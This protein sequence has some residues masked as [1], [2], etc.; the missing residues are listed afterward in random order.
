M[1]KKIERTIRN[2]RNKAKYYKNFNRKYTDYFNF[3]FDTTAHLPAD[4]VEVMKKGCKLLDEMGIKYSLADGTLLGVVRDNKLIPHDTDIDIAVLHPADAKQ[5]EKIFT[6]NRF[7]VGRRAA[8]KGIIQQLV[9]YS[10]SNCLF[11]IIFYTKIGDE[12]YNFCEKD[13]YFQH[14]YHNYE[15]VV[16]YEFEGHTFYIPN[17]VEGW[18][19]ATYGDWRTPNG[20]KPKDWREGG[21][22][23]LTAVAYDGNIA[24]TIEKITQEKENK[25]K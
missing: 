9:F 2:I 1:L 8:F 25:V 14:H 21:N 13:F 11:D 18:L 12:V 23:Y 10:E 15:S 20:S 4:A 3:P 24:K 16:P 22:Q 19:E 17:D 7:K 6:K 5:I